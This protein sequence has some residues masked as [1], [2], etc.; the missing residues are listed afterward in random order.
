MGIR[1]RAVVR[2]LADIVA[3]GERIQGAFHAPHN[4]LVLGMGVFLNPCSEC[5][6]KKWGI[7]AVDALCLVGEKVVRARDLACCCGQVEAK[8]SGALNP[9]GGCPCEQEQ[10]GECGEA[11]R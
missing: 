5:F 11:G 7:I 4:D 2:T 6:L 3:F 9:L 8:V 1:K 10:Y